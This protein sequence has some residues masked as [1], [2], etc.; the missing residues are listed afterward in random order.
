MPLLEITKIG[1]DDIA[2]IWAVMLFPSN[3]NDRKKYHLIDQIKH[4]LNNKS[5]VND[6]PMKRADIELLLDC[7]SSN[8][9]DKLITDNAKKACI[10]GDLAAMIYAMII[11]N[12]VEPSINKAIHVSKKFASPEYGK[13]ADGTSLPISKQ[14]I[15]NCWNE[16][17][18]VVHLWGAFRLC[19]DYENK[20]INEIVTE[21]EYIHFLQVAA[22]ILRLG[23]EFVLH[24][25]KTNTTLFSVNE[26]WELP[27]NIEPLKLVA[28]DFPALLKKLLTDYE[29]PKNNSY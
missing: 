10:A 2:N 28:E 18:S 25:Q 7:L 15:R 6:F 13:F 26:M 27:P 4:D 9:W 12:F 22:G 20:K 8:S 3:A 11:F 19:A 17:K 23:R 24:R 21:N 29:A 1:N 5:D 16:Y 14:T